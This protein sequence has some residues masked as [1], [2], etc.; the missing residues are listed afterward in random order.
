M[1][2]IE[3]AGDGEKNS[4]VACQALSVVLPPDA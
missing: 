4:P 1:E 2:E 3:T